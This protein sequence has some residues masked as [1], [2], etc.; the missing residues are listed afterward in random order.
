MT[1]ALTVKTELG[2]GR[3]AIMMIYQCNKTSLALNQQML[4]EILSFFLTQQMLLQ[5]LSL[6]VT[7]I[8]HHHNCL[9]QAIN[10]VCK[11]TGSPVI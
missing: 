2:G 1:T 5:D 8:I 10:N 7:A 4:T 6:K 3:M 11:V 9:P